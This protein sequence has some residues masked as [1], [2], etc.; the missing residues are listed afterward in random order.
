MVR[1]GGMTCPLSDWI[2]GGGTPRRGGIAGGAVDACDEDR[3]GGIG[4]GTAI[5]EGPLEVV[6]RGRAGAM[7]AECIGSG[8]AGAVGCEAGAKDEMG[9]PV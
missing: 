2:E 8:V 6:R 5:A 9:L 1:R 4:G 3:R 7:G